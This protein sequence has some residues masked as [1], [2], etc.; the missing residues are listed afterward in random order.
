VVTNSRDL[1]FVRKIQIRFYF[2][3][4]I[5]IQ[6]LFFLEYMLFKTYAVKS[7]V[8]LTNI[9]L[10]WL[11]DQVS[12]TNEIDKYLSN[13][14]PLIDNKKKKK[15]LLNLLEDFSNIIEFSENKK[16]FLNFKKFNYN[17][18][19]IIAIAN[20][21]FTTSYE[22]QIL[23]FFYVSKINETISYKDFLFK[24]KKKIDVAEIAFVEIFLKKCKFNLIKISKFQYLFSLL[25]YLIKK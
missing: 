21:N 24:P 2:K 5:V 1:F 23:Q 9:K 4:N 18:N 14:K 22:F 16:I 3:K 15:Y 10:K 6:S 11:F 8:F 12:E 13:L 25:K 7:E 20:E 19:K 17:F